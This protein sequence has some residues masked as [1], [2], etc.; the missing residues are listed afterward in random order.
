MRAA[1]RLNAVLCARSSIVAARRA[2]GADF[3]CPMDPFFKYSDIRP[4]GRDRSSGSL[5]SWCRCVNPR[6]AVLSVGVRGQ[7]LNRI[8]IWLVRRCTRMPGVQYRPSAS[9]TPLVYLLL[10]HAFYARPYR[11]WAVKRTRAFKRYRGRCPDVRGRCAI[12]AP[13]LS[14]VRQS[15]DSVV[16]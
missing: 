11:E 12:V 10:S 4:V 3:P 7:T 14:F 6:S 15:T 8:A 13:F 2:V 16:S 5:P 9:L 1:R